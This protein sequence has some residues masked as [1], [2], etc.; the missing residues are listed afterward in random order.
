MLTLSLGL[1]V[2]GSK[3]PEFKPFLKASSIVIMLLI[4][5][6]YILPALL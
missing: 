6:I 5:S 2:L 1:P 4:D 3:D